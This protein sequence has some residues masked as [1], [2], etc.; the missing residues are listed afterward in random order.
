M[1]VPHTPCGELKAKLLKAEANLHYSSRIKFVEQMGRSIREMLCKSD[2]D[3]Q[4]CQRTDC[5]P[6]RGRPGSCMRQ[7]ALYQIIC[8]DCKLEGRESVYCGETGRTLYDRGAE[9]LQAHNR[10]DKESV[11]VEHEDEEHGG[12]M[13]SWVMMPKGFPR[14]NLLRQALE[15]HM[16]TTNG[17]KNL[18]NRRGEWGQNLPPKLTLNTEVTA[19]SRKRVGAQMPNQ[20]T[21]DQ[22]G[23]MDP[24]DPSQAPPKK[25]RQRVDQY[26]EQEQ[27]VQ[28]H[29]EQ[30]PKEEDGVVQGTPQ[31]GPKTEHK[32][33]TKPTRIWSA[34]EMIDYMRKGKQTSTRK[35]SKAAKLS[36][37][38]TTNLIQTTLKLI[39]FTSIQPLG[40]PQGQVG[41]DASKPASSQSL[42]RE[43]K[44]RTEAI[45]V[46]IPEQAE[47]SQNLDSEEGYCQEGQRD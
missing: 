46:D 3:P 30:S 40:E 41:S 1:F 6:C 8:Q 14:G 47:R 20:Q 38:S 31:I 17:E 15:A 7:G 33:A 37:K 29:G 10:R 2:P 34:K 21:L 12:N 19:M 44:E 43:V 4:E 23:S 26:E 25:K 45:V 11:M 22:D 36:H 18:L 32:D 42:Y 16:I 24:Q 13:V 9:H 28:G 39:N 5:F 27:D 35:S